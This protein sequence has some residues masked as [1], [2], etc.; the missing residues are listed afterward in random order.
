MIGNISSSILILVRENDSQ[1]PVEQGLL[2]QQ[3]LTEANHSE[4]TLIIYPHLGDVF[5]SSNQWITSL[6]PLQECVLQDIFEWLAS[7]AREVYN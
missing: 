3:R 1:T 4:H 6:G 7:S 5:Y 2:S